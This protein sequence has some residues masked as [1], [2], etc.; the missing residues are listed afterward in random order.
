MGM[1]FSIGEGLELKIVSIYY[2]IILSSL[3]EAAR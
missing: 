1:I 2:L 3:G